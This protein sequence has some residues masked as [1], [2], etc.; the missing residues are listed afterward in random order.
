LAPRG[1]RLQQEENMKKDVRTL[2]PYIHLLKPKQQTYIVYCVKTYGNLSDFHR[3]KL[4][5]LSTQTAANCLNV[6][7]ERVKASYTPC[8]PGEKEIPIVGIKFIR[9][10]IDV[11]K[12]SLT[13]YLY[14]D[15]ESVTM[16]L[17][18]AS[19]ADEFGRRYGDR[20]NVSYS[21]WKQDDL[22]NLQ[23][24]GRNKWKVTT[25]KAKLD[26]ATTW[27]AETFR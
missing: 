13:N 11:F 8:L 14:Q 26:Q 1:E 25:H 19:L 22:I 16:M 5:F 15:E 7:L 23:R 17:R 21:R 3:G 20:F 6:A 10:I 2:N 18:D 9:E 12:D 27:L 4:P 24:L